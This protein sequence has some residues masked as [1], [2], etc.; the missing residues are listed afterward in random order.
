ML[1][2]TRNYITKI[3]ITTKLSKKEIERE[4]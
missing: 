1:K 4:F 3:K 2:I